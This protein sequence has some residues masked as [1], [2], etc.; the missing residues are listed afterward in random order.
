MDVV[1]DHACKLEAEAILRLE[2]EA[3]Q[4]ILEKTVLEMEKP[5]WE[6][7]DFGKN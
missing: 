5:I 6:N 4:P 7:N 2:A 1:R 3:I